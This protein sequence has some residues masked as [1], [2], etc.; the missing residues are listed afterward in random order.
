MYMSE[1]IDAYEADP[2]GATLSRL[3][4]ALLVTGPLFYRCHCYG[5]ADERGVPSLEVFR[6]LRRAEL[7]PVP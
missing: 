6:H 3:E 1:L 2:S 7:V 5:I 4:S